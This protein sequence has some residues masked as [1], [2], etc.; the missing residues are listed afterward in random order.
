MSITMSKPWRPATEAELATLPSTTGVYE[1]RRSNGE[2]LD[3]GYAGSRSPFG[4]AS[5]IA[6]AVAAHG[7]DD[8]EFRHEIHVQYRSRHI[9]LVLVHRSQEG[10]LPPALAKRFAHIRGRISPS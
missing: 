8:L 1:L 2:L 4:L 6:E 10:G 5:T 9:E 3:I 7:G